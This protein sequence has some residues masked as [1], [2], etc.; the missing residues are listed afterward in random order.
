MNASLVWN[1]IATCIP[2]FSAIMWLS[3]LLIAR[4]DS[5]TLLE[6]SIKHTLLWFYGLSVFVWLS[7]YIY[8]YLPAGFVYIG[9]FTYVAALWMMVSYYRYICQLTSPDIREYG[10]VWH[11][12][13][14]AVIPGGL[15][16]CSFFVPFDVQL[17]LVTGRGNWVR[18]YE[19]YSFLFLSKPMLLG[20]YG[21]AYSITSALALFI[22]YAE[23]KKKEDAPIRLTRWVMLLIGITLTLLVFALFMFLVPRSELT[24]VGGFIALIVLSCAQ[25][26][27]L[28]YNVI[29]RNFLL[30]LVKVKEAEEEHIK[31]PES[32]LPAK[33]EYKRTSEVRL[34]REGKLVST[35]LTRKRFEGYIQTHKPHL[36]P[37][38]KITDL[39]VPLKVNRTVLSNFVNQTYGFNFNRYINHLRLKE[40]ERLQ[41]MPSNV[42][43]EL[44]KLIVMAGFSDI[45][46]YQRAL[47][48]KQE[49]AESSNDHSITNRKQ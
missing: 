18:G 17:E 13:I 44:S 30:Y 19:A 16:V 26:I 9:S 47:D 10:F 1:E 39:T 34:S 49:Q 27:V 38:L 32:P 31:A 11:Y 7:F 4:Y 14:A 35:P 42:N 6:R 12:L 3:M 36:N 24:I 2:C 21:L 37:K 8:N 33:R 29:R 45:R 5:Y 40:V 22:Y 46:H 15:L 20:I 43:I 25:H 48:M 23:A 28:G 41:K